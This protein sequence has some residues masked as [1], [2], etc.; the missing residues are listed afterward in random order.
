[1]KK[2]IVIILLKEAEE[3]FD[4]LP[5]KVKNKFIFSFTK[6]EL[7]YKGDWFEKLKSTSGIFEF[8]QRDS[9]KFYRI[10]AFWDSTKEVKTLI[11]G[12]HGVDKKSNKT[13]KREIEKAEKIKSKYFNSNKK[14]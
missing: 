6:T 2:E 3:Y 13:P 12:T 10:F 9:S 7:G 8:R 14:K 11:I 4:N 5:D 1:M